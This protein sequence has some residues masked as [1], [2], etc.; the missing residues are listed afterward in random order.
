MRAR[1]QGRFA[2]TPAVTGSRIDDEDDDDDE[3]DEEGSPLSGVMLSRDPVRTADRRHWCPCGS[4]G[5][6]AA[7][8][9]SGAPGPWCVRLDGERGGYL[10]LSFFLE[11][12]Q[13]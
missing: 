7:P 6:G 8:R 2:L 3:N 12:F 5:H 11:T 4:P 13:I 10:G 1:L 9:A